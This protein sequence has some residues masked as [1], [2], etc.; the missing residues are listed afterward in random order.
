MTNMER[1]DYSNN[2]I[3]EILWILLVIC[4]DLE[5]VK[6]EEREKDKI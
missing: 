5:E 3:K 4:S 2:R 6:I 1:K